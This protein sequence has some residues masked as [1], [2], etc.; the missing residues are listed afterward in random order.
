MF[1]TPIAKICRA[2][3]QKPIKCQ[4]QCF[5]ISWYFSDDL[6]LLYCVSVYMEFVYKFVYVC[7][8]SWG[9]WAS[10]SDQKS[11]RPAPRVSQSPL[12][13]TTGFHSLIGV[14]CLNNT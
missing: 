11:G 9:Y 13:T 12:S 14:E 8:S 4:E 7:F 1:Y 6:L 3:L 5:P 10:A 2:G